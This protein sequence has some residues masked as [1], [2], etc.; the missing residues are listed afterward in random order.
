M[1]GA[2]FCWGTIVSSTYIPTAT[3]WLYGI[4]HLVTAHIP[5]TLTTAWLLGHQTQHRDQR[6]L[7]TAGDNVVSADNHYSSRATLVFANGLMLG[8]S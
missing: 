6:T 2:V 7:V 5:V 1:L 8:T 4:Y 3:T